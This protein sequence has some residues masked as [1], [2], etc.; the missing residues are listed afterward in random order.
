MK[1]HEL[2]API[3]ALALLIAN[4]DLPAP[5]IDISTVFPDRLRL[6]FHD[7]PEGFE[8][9]LSAL[10]VDPSTVTGSTSGSSETQVRRA[11]TTYA[12]ADIQLTSFTPAGG[13]P[14]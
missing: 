4:R 5:S 9:W 11:T 8:A 6:D 3:A 7:D 13:E 12:G 14:S 1:L 10:G 2:S